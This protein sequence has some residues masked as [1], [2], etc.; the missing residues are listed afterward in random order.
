MLQV[1]LAPGVTATAAHTS[2]FQ[3]ETS[4][5]NQPRRRIHRFPVVPEDKVQGFFF[6]Q[7]NRGSIWRRAFRE[8]LSWIVFL[9]ST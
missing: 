8:N 6:T 7:V 2:E 5:I 4:G 1:L 3:L 9:S